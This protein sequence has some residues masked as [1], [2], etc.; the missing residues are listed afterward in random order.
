MDIHRYTYIVPALSPQPFT[1]A[2]NEFATTPAIS[3]L[4]AS[5]ADAFS[6]KS[7]PPA[8]TKYRGGNAEARGSTRGSKMVAA[9]PVSKIHDLGSILGP[10]FLFEFDCIFHWFSMFY[11]DVYCF[12]NILFPNF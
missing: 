9:R 5:P 8:P 2:V 6:N 4:T 11:N 7:A 10:D 1:T 12:S 3:K